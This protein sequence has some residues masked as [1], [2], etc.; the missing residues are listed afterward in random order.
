MNWLDII[1]HSIALVVAL[2][3]VAIVLIY[4]I[5]L[6]LLVPAVIVL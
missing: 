1:V 5:F 4:Q 2:L 3:L 6:V